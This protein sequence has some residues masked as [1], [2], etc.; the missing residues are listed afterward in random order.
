[1]NDKQY[2]A[3][4][5]LRERLLECP[6]DAS[7]DMAAGYGAEYEREQIKDSETYTNEQRKFITMG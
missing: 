5:I 2:Q 7:D 3:G 4:R 1:M 6:V